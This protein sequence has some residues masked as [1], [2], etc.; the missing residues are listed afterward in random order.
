MERVEW[1]E[2][3]DGIAGAERSSEQRS[4][5]RDRRA[6]KRGSR[7]Q[8]RLVT[9]LRALERVATLAAMPRR[10]ILGGTLAAAIATAVAVVTAAAVRGGSDCRRMGAG[11]DTRAAGERRRRAEREED[12]EC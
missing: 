6:E 1:L 5:G 12:G 11:R 7:A 9:G 10:G 2:P 4:G 3:R 8:D